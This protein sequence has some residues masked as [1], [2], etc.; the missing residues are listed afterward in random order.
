MTA[1]GGA[2][3]PGAPAAGG[4]DPA[5]AAE[6]RAAL[7]ARAGDMVEELR[8]LVE[9]ESP[10]GDVDR[11]TTLAGVIAEQWERVGATVT[12]H[13]HPGTGP[14]LELWWP[15][16]AGTPGTAP[17]TLL[18][19]HYDT[20]HDVGTLRRNPWRIDDEGR[21]WGPGA[22]DM[23]SGLVIA[24][25]GLA[26]LA[27][28]GHALAR[29]VLALI[30]AD[31]EI[32]SPTS[33]DLVRD[34]ARGSAAALVFEAANSDGALKTARKGVGLWS[35]TVRG[36]AA[37]AGQRFFEGVNAN[38][39]L[40]ELV[41]TIAGLSDPVTGTTVNVGT[42]RGGSRA[43]V[44][45]EHAVAMIDVRFTSD[46]EASRV[47]AALGALRSPLE[48]GIEVRGGVNRPAMQRTAATAELFARARACADALGFAL[49]ESAAGGASDGNFT[50]A[51]GT[52]TLDGLG[53]VGAGL[54]TAQE[55]VRVAS[56]PE[57]AALLAALL[58]S[59]TP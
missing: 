51:G 57:R 39:G 24:R 37:H 36:R 45:A 5:R 3:D 56:L 16:P 41:S 32:G 44:V 2:A 4:P 8:T 54:H 52:P 18:V 35:V 22:Q 46:D 30:T 34:R 31:E 6:L 28:A 7:D 19:G 49:S 48:V 20:V 29:P 38:V 9:H 59:D 13:E 43:N 21:A 11:L 42:M 25:N 53:G 33:A 40:A 1:G 47:A 14:H 12:R 15:G 26:A 17:P 50:A 55:Y 10:T 23:K 58:A 27:D